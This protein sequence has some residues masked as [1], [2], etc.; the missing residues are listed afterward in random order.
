MFVIIKG[1]GL[2]ILQIAII[3]VEF[4]IHAGRCDSRKGTKLN[5]GDALGTQNL[6]PK[7][8]KHH[9]PKMLVSTPH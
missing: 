2:A 8:D 9:V 5:L 1:T 7:K 3:N 4:L 6:I